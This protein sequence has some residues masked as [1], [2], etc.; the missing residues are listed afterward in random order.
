MLNKNINEHYPSICLQLWHPTPDFTKHIYYWP[1]Q[2]HCEESES[3]IILPETLNEFRARMNTVLDFERYDVI[4]KSPAVLAGV[5]AIDLIACRHFRIPVTP[6]FLYQL[7][8]DNHASEKIGIA[9]EFVAE[10]SL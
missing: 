1:A 9:I 2:Y 10:K 4:S 5:P 6:F 8:R 3:S 7:L